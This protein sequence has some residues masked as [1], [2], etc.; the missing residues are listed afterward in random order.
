[1]VRRGNGYLLALE[2]DA[3]DACRFV[4]VSSERRGAFAEDGRDD[5]RVCVARKVGG[6]QPEALGGAVEQQDAARVD[7]V[8][9]GDGRCREGLVRVGADVRRHLHAE[10][11]DG[12]VV[13]HRGLEVGDLVAAVRRRQHVLD[14]RLHPLQRA[15]E[16]SGLMTWIRLAS[17][18]STPARSARR[19]CGAWWVA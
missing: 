15:L 13:L 9:V 2:R 11:G 16:L 3:V 6:E 4:A 10:R 18:P 8:A 12:A 19:L 7:A 1:M 17:M 5:G 14:P